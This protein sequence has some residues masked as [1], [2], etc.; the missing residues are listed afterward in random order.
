MTAAARWMPMSCR[1][2]SMTWMPASAL[3]SILIV[4]PRLPDCSSLFCH[5]LE[6]SS[7][8]RRARAETQ[9]PNN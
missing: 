8:G 6:F 4:A 3:A 2:A 1:G 9:N 5:I 7:L